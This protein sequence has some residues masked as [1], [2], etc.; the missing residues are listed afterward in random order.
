MAIEGRAVTLSASSYSTPTFCCSCGAPQQTQIETSRS[1]K[2]GNTTTTLRMRFPY[3]GPCAARIKDFQSKLRVSVLIA[4]AVAVV[5][6]LLIFAVTAIPFA[7]AMVLA[8]LIGVGVPV[9]IAVATRP[10]PPPAPATATGEAAKIVSFQSGGQAT[11]YCTNAAWAEAFAHANGAQ[12]QPKSKGDG[13]RTGAIVAAVIAAPGGAIAAWMVGHPTVHVD[14][15]GPESLQIY[16]DGAKA[17]VIPANANAFFDVG[18]GKRTFGWSKIGDDKPTSTV[19]GNVTINDAHL[20]NP[21]KNACYWLIAD[22]YGTASVDGIAQ[23]PQPLQEMY[24]FDKVDTWFGENPQSIEVSSGGSGGTRVALQRSKACMQFVSRGCTLESR[25]MLVDCERAAKNKVEFDQCADRA[26]ANCGKGTP[27]A[28]T[29]TAAGPGVAAKTT[30]PV[31]APP[32][33]VKKK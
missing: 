2:R 11:V 13:F 9:G 22:S 30:V 16:V 33:V 14:N 17:L 10:K 20:Y 27:P 12:I 18:H 32:A 15:G 29:S 6:S 1:Q 19:E 7:V 23:G 28:S 25:S 26:M 5:L 4:V 24:A 31:K 8:A 3:C 21:Q